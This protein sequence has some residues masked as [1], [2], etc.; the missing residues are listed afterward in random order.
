MSVKKV[1]MSEKK[2]PIHPIFYPKGTVRPVENSS[3]CILTTRRT[4][5]V[6]L[7]ELKE[8]H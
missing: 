8:V 5:D 2:V 4:R 7:G 6:L 3:P 1:P